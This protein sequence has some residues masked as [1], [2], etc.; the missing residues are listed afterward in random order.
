MYKVV[1]KYIMKFG[2]FGSNNYD[3]VGVVY[4]E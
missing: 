2:K 4:K 3:F 1:K